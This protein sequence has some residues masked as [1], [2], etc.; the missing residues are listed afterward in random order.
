M[1]TENAAS[2]SQLLAPEC[3]RFTAP[4]ANL[5]LLPD[6]AIT[7]FNPRYLKFPFL[8]HTERC[9]PEFTH[10]SRKVCP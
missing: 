6:P 9:S 3:K 7:S 10:N 5:L 4:I 2:Y 1:T 8:S